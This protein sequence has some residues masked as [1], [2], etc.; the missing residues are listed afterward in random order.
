MTLDE[1]IGEVDFRDKVICVLGKAASGKTYV[2]RTISTLYPIPLLSTDD[3]RTGNYEEDLYTIL[4]H[5]QDKKGA[6]VVEG[7][8]CPRL[9]RKGLQPEYNFRPDIVIECLIS[10]A[11]QAEIYRRERDAKK[12]KYMRAFNAGL[13]KI[14]TEYLFALPEENKPLIIELQNEY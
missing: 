8:Q 4:E 12:L 10:D 2:G 9:L 3:F 11:K 1:L 14:Y 6:L 13:Q 5:L 7:V